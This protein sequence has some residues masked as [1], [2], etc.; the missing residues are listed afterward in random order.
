MKIAKDLFKIAHELDAAGLYSIADQLDSLAEDVIYRYARAGTLDGILERALRPGTPEEGATAKAIL[1]KRLNAQGKTLSSFLSEKGLSPDALNKS[2]A[3]PAAAA[4]KG[5]AKPGALVRAPSGSTALAPSAPKPSSIAPKPAPRA[6]VGAG[7]L[8]GAVGAHAGATLGEAIGGETGAFVGGFLGGVGGQALA[9]NP[10]GRALLAGWT[11]GT[12]INNIPLIRGLIDGAINSTI[13]NDDASVDD[14]QLGALLQIFEKTRALVD[15]PSTP[16]ETKVKKAQYLH[17]L[18]PKLTQHPAASRVL[19]AEGIAAMN[20]LAD[21]IS[22]DLAAA[23]AAPETKAAPAPKKAVPKAWVRKLQSDLNALA[24]ARKI[25]LPARLAEDGLYGPKT[26][27]AV[28]EFDPASNGVATRAV[29]TDIASALTTKKSNYPA[30][31]MYHYEEL[32]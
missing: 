13:E 14:K 21:K 5:G 23:S 20:T 3:N 9:A 22:A 12:A 25:T 8:G 32:L 19:T 15:N 16:M 28:K 2:Q 31:R 18:I 17:E 24:S 7:V 10:Y 11:I 26:R 30:V 27:A 1:E 29:L 6:G 4:P